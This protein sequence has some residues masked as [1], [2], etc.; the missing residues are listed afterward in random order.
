MHTI[1]LDKKSRLVRNYERTW[2]TNASETMS[3]CTLFWGT[4]L[5]PFVWMF[6]ALAFIVVAVGGPTV[7]TVRRVP[8]PHI[9]IPK[10]NI[11]LKR[12]EKMLIAIADFLQRHV[13]FFERTWYGLLIVCGTAVLTT[14]V[15]EAI[16]NP[17]EFFSVI[18]ACLGAIAV[19][20]IIFIVGVAFANSHASG[21]IGN[22]FRK[23]GRGIAFPFK[24]LALGI[25][26]FKTSTCPKVSIIGAT[27]DSHYHGE[28]LERAA[29]RYNLV[30]R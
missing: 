13:K 23:L 3:F 4:V 17:I 27:D 2:D 14:I 30:E 22:A 26:S 9:D 16:T 15:Y 8:T 18:G 25:Y 19:V 29:E 21:R 20:S 6:W 10:P 24:F 11:K 5:T 28:G 1:Y 12:T 7:K